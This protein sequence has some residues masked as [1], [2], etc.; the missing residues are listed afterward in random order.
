MNEKALHS[1]LIKF[2][3]NRLSEQEHQEFVNWLNS[4]SEKRVKEVLAQYSSFFENNTDFNLPQYQGLKDKINNQLNYLDAHQSPVIE[5]H[6]FTLFSRLRN[7]A[8]AAIILICSFLG[9]YLYRPAIQQSVE[10]IAKRGQR[11]VPGSN[12]ASLTL[13]DGRTII[14]ANEANG[15]LALQNGSGIDKVKDGQI[16]YKRVDR[17][18]GKNAGDNI[19]T[20]PAGGQYQVILPDGTKVWLNAA[21]TLRFPS[22]FSGRERVVNLDGEAYFEVA[23]NKAMPFMVNVNHTQVRV[24]GTHFNI[25]GYKNEPD[26]HTTLLEGSVKIINGSSSKNIVPGQQAIVNNQIKV[27]SVD[28]SQAVGWKNGNFTFSHENIRVVMNKIARWYNVDIQYQ[29]KVT[30][31]EFVGTIPRSK[32]ITE[33]LHKLELTGLLKFRLKERSVLV[34]N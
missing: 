15:R 6:Q 29:G 9:L 8:V 27:I 21:T 13:A 16:A 12:K 2:T 4:A 20:I 7:V 25:M 33:V 18:T 22:A 3:E 30:N 24:L 31:E 19:L 14:L 11:I 17:P 34:M 28:T 23:K 26:T 32:D 5:S 10:P 1:L